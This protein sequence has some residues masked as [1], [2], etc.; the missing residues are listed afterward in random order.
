[1][2]TN[3]RAESLKTVNDQNTKIPGL[4]TKIRCQEKMPNWKVA[5]HELLRNKSQQYEATINEQMNV[6]NHIKVKRKRII[7]HHKVN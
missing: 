7:H 6:L 1:M 2:T 4:N 5:V 3:E